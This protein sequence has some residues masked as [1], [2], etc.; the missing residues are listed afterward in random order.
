MRRKKGLKYLAMNDS[1]LQN[2]K[3][4]GLISFE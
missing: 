1:S 3:N 4:K 2:K